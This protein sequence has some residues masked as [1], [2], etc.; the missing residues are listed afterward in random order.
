MR[1]AAVGI[2]FVLGTCLLT[3]QQA[4]VLPS[5]MRFEVA[6]I[7]PA[8]EVW[9]ALPD[10]PT[11]FARSQVTAYQLISIAYRLPGQRLEGG[12]S[13]I[14]SERFDIQAISAAPTTTAEKDVLLQRLL[15]E[16]F[17]L[18]VHVEQRPQPVYALLLARADGRIGPN[19]KRSAF[20]C[21]AHAAAGGSA[22]K[23]P[24]QPN[25]LP[26]CY[27]ALRMDD[28]VRQFTIG[29][30]TM[31]AFAAALTSVVQRVVV[32][33]TELSGAFDIDITYAGQQ[34]LLSG[35]GSPNAASLFTVLNEEL[36]LRLDSRT[37]P[38]EVLVIDSA[39]RPTPN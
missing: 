39:E 15:A 18:K 36:G 34:D 38:V 7:R 27:P 22:D 21:A 6:S 28:G 13:W 3:A 32:D 20:D 24:R 30:V 26:S 14:H 37:E 19:L 16:R 25:G 2:L 5:D 10:T 4:M 8:A 17:A 9:N 29:G 31:A 1:C 12:P 35:T 23:I 11:R 33:R